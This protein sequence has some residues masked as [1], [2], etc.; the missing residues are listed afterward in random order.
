MMQV[1]PEYAI[2]PTLN[3]TLNGSSAVLLL[4]G[5]WYINRGK[6]AIQSK[7]KKAF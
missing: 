2:Y 6:M 3:A 1:P 4:A 7:P 5:R